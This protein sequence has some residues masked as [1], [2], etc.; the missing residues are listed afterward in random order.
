MIKKFGTAQWSG[1]LQDGTGTIS[2]QSG[3]LDA[4]QYG[5]NK[6]FQDEPGTNPEELIGAAHAACFAMALSNIMGEDDIVPDKIDAKSTIHLDMSD[7]PK[8]VKAHIEVTIKA[9]ADESRI[10]EAAGKAKEGCPVS[11][12]LD[13]EITMDAKVA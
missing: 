13:C 8:I 3:A 1:G 2:S 4:L 10:M 12:L 11:Q 5:F 7:G 9:D 6:R